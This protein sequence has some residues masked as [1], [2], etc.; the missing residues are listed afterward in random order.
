[1]KLLWI[2][3]VGF[4][5]ADQLQIRFFIFLFLSSFFWHGAGER[6]EYNETEHQLFRLPRKPVI[7]LGRE[8]VQHS[9]RVRGM[10]ETSLAD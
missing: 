5:I 8:I 6:W 2:I 4:D 9:H 1:M 7:L 10:H 3:S